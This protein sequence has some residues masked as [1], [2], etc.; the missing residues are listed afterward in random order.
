MPS[1]KTASDVKI[2]NIDGTIKTTSGWYMHIPYYY[3]SSGYIYYSSRGEAN[4]TDGTIDIRVSFSK[5][6]S[7]ASYVYDFT[8]LFTSGSCDFGFNGSRKKIT[9]SI[10][11][12]SICAPSC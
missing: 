8:I 4:S 10:S 9:K 1:G 5:G 11:L 3:S 7:S 12:C 6:S 2:I